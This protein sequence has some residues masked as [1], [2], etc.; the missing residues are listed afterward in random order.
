MGDAMITVGAF[1]AKTNLSSL[2]ERVEHGEE[3][4]ITRH[5]KAIA[6]LVPAA[7]ADRAHMDEAI[8]RLKKL[9]AGSSL[10]GLSWKDLRD[11]GRR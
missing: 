10:G 11:E 7:L 5:G 3:V 2:L 1:E 9:R 4:L 6:R 8:A